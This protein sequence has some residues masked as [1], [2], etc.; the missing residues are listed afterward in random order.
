MRQRYRS[1]AVW[2]GLILLTLE[3]AAWGQSFDRQKAGVVRV[4][5]QVEGLRKTGTGFIVGLD[6]DA[7]YIVTASHVVEG[8][9]QPRVEFFT[10]RNATVQA[11][12]ARIEGGDP[13]GLALL[14]VRGKDNLPPGLV[15]L[16]IAQGSDLNGGEPVTVIGFPQGGGSWAVLRA[17][18][19][20]REG[21]DLTLD[22]SIA[23]GNSGGPVLMGES[24]IGVITQVGGAGKFG[25]AV[26]APLVRLVLDG[27][28]V[29]YG[30]GAV[31]AAATTS[32][33]STTATTSPALRV[34]RIVPEGA[35]PADYKGPCP[36]VIDFTWKVWAA[37]GGG[38]VSYQVVRGD[39]V[40]GEQQTLA[41][42]GPGSKD[43]RASWQL[44][45]ADSSRDYSS[46][47]ALRVLGPQKL[48]S[49]KLPF[50][51]QCL[52][53]PSAVTVDGCGLGQDPARGVREAALRHRVQ[54]H[55]ER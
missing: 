53:G 31:E 16:P 32:T 2:F 50:T 34:E 23:E 42:E 54:N 7:A 25:R 35:H 10:K 48:D 33:P 28:G 6:S 29:R 13:R 41:F 21:R 24:V 1:P 14:I 49:D 30:K 18:I 9:S 44:G 22:G 17:N 20:S 37:G 12:T 3:T 36:A 4:T 8:D 46:W 27:W 38:N 51:L 40:I 15:A 11:E 39:G 52:P 19:A 26:P 55:A 5:S 45:R 43:V 47:V